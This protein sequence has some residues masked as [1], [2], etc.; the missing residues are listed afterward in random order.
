MT[1]HELSQ[2]QREELK[3][4][5]LEEYLGNQPSWNE[6]AS[7]DDIVS[8]SYINEAYKGVCFTEDDFLTTKNL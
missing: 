8:D 4:N 1:V 2:S 3:V 7:A 5:S 6:I